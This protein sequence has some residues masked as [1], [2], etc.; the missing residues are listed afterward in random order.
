VWGQ[1]LPARTRSAEFTAFGMFTSLDPDY[2]PYVN[3]GFTVG[4]D[5]TKLMKFTSISLE[6]RFKNAPG[7]EVGEKTA[8]GGPRF[9]YRWTR[10][11]L[12]A[13]LFASAGRITFANKYA[14]GSNSTG[15]NGSVV[16]TYGGGIDY[17]ITGQWAARF[18]AQS[19]HWDLEEKPKILLAPTALSV[20]IIYKVRF[21][22]DRSRW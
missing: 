1:S 22:K 20:G 8:G 21:P 6:A 9:E 19:E 11:H 17:D 2:G 4:A 18:D 5:F 12:Y 16:Y 15:Y 10:I 13:D 7:V 14:R 3:P